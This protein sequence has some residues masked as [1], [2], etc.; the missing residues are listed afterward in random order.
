[1]T[2]RTRYS[3]D[4]KARVALDAIREELTLAELSKKHGVHL[5]PAGVCS[6]TPRGHDDQR[7]EASGDPLAGRACLHAREARIWRRHLTRTLDLWRRTA[8]LRLT[9]CIP[10][11]ANWCFSGCK[12]PCQPTG[13]TRFFETGLR[14]LSK[15]RR[16]MCIEKQHPRL[17][18]RRQCKL[19]SIARQVMLASSRGAD[20]V[21]G[22]LSSRWRDR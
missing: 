22:L 4:F 21:W 17:S 2:K 10:R 18:V 15:E 13:G 11:L 14:S 8:K 16:Q 9:N 3:A 20:T 7:L 6:Q 19:L 1:M 5:L 12:H